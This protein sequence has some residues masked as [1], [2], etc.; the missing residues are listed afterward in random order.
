MKIG[1]TKVL[2][3]PFNRG[4]LRIRFPLRLITKTAKS[5]GGASSGE[6]D[7]VG[8]PGPTSRDRAQDP[9]WAC[10]PP[11][12]PP[13]QNSPRAHRPERPLTTPGASGPRRG[14]QS[15][16]SRVPSPRSSASPPDC[17]QSLSTSGKK[18]PAIFARPTS[19]PS[20]GAAPHRKRTAS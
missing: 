1:K 19:G 2:E 5:S 10:G 8:H 4:T 9:R 11:L 3:V 16:P 17:E 12:Q 20:L 13:Q 6:P 7:S 14:P 18:S 15:L